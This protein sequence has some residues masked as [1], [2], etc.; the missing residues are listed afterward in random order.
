MRMIL[1][2][3]LAPA[4]SLA[5][6]L[7]MALTLCGP[8]FATPAQDM[9]RDQIM[10]GNIAGV[11]AAL[12]Q[13]GVQDA[14]PGADPE[15]Q[16]A[17]FTV[18]WVTDPKIDA[19]TAKWLA[20]APSSAYAMTA[21]AKYLAALGRANRGEDT[22]RTTYPAGVDIMQALD[23]EALALFVAASKAEPGLLA[24]SDGLLV[25]TQTVAPEATL[26][27]ELERIM[28]LHPNR[29]SLMRAMFKLA[30]QWGGTADQVHI[31]CDRYA[32]MVTTP[33]DYTPEVCVVDAVF[34]GRFT[35][36]AMRDAARV[37]LE[38]L[39]NPV[40]D[41]ARLL[42][43][44]DN[45][46]TAAH[47]LAVLDKVKSE[48]PLTANE[49]LIWDIA[50]IEVNNIQTLPPDDTPTYKLALAGGL[51]DLRRAADRDP[52]YTTVV[53]DYISQLEQNF[54]QNGTDF[55]RADADKRLQRLLA[56]VP[57]SWRA[58]LR[59]AQLHYDYKPGTLQTTSDYL[60]NAIAYSNYGQIALQQ[61]LSGM[62]IMTDGY[63]KRKATA[64]QLN[65]TPQDVAELDG[66]GR[67]PIVA[68]IR[69]IQAVCDERGIG[70][71]ECFSMNYAFLLDAMMADIQA[72][73]VCRTEASAPLESLLHG[74]VPVDF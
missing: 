48:R 24:A 53:V 69:I 36:G 2:T 12:A 56:A 40:L 41:Y 54:W 61:A 26:P 64:G 14:A 22:A 43:V 29:G 52:F 67:C 68:L 66:L 28:A 7:A 59:L 34:Y 49:G 42:D 1:K 13:A 39:S 5:A 58:W 62:I 44:M 38:T 3:I 8:A 37:A 31:V 65:Q 23:T 55:D 21:R 46:G 9:F 6:L 57:H 72:R 18:F 32:P 15:L 35:Q 45:K 17:L 73:E 51:E 50:N 70:H 19:F 27:L 20:K 4:A 63:S 74:P 11:D 33:K 71:Q 10:A 47:R 30:P 25:Q 16:R 60:Q